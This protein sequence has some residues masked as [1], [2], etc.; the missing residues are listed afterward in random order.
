[1]PSLVPSVPVTL[2]RPR[3][4]RLDNAAL[5]MAEVELSR[6][7]GKKTSLIRTMIDPEAIGLNDLCVMLWAGC[8]HEDPTLTREQ[9]REAM[10]LPQL[11]SYLEAIYQAWN[12]ASAPAEEA[13]TPETNAPF[14]S[15][16][17]GSGTGALPGSSLASV[18]V[19]SGV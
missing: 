16:F 12:V 19:N 4:L 15:T 6:I 1:M 9:V 5:F 14:P 17:P 11:G 7:W 2:D 10:S 8:L 18:T 3:Q 13:L